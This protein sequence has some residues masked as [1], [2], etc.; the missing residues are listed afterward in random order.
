MRL[1]QDLCSAKTLRPVSCEPCINPPDT[2]GLGNWIYVSVDE[3]VI[4]MEMDG[5]AKFRAR[6]NPAWGRQCGYL[7]Q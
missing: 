1:A 6:G 5:Y 4:D 2:L 7:S 3:Y